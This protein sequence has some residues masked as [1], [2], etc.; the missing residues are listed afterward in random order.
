MR[1]VVLEPAGVVLKETCCVENTPTH[2]EDQEYWIF[3][4][5]IMLNFKVTKWG[6]CNSGSGRTAT[7][8]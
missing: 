5:E 6:K 4:L 3:E 1:W 7:A 8:V 2:V